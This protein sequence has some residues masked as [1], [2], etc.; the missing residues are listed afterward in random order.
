AGHGLLGAAVALAEDGLTVFTG[1]ISLSTHPWL[2]DHVVGGAVLVPGTAFVELALH[3]GDYV[4]CDHLEELTIEAPLV[5]EEEDHVSLQ[6]VVETAEAAGR[7][8]FRLSA[9][10]PSGTWIR[11]ATGTLVTGGDIGREDTVVRGNWPPPGARAVDLGDFYARVADLGTE[12]GPVFQGMT[13]L[14]QDGDDLYAEIDLP[15]GTE[16]SGYGIHPALLDAALHPLATT[17]DTATEGPMLPFV[18]TGVRLHATGADSL[19]VHWTPA[20]SAAGAF[21]CRAVDPSGA[22]VLTADSLV[23]REAPKSLASA[24]GRGPGLTRLDW[25]STTLAPGGIPAGEKWGVLAAPSL[26]ASE[27]MEGNADLTELT[28]YPDVAALAEAGVDAAVLPLLWTHDGASLPETVHTRTAGLLA[29]VQE[30]LDDPR[31][32]AA[33]LLVVTRG[34][35]LVTGDVVP[36]DLAASAAWGLLRSVQSEQPGRI[37]LV[38][39]DDDQ[40]SL[41]LLP[42]V[43]AGGEPQ[44]ALRHGRAYV[45]RLTR[46]PEHPSATAS[47][48]ADVGDGTVLVTGGTGSLGALVARHL[49]VEHGVRHLLLTSRRGV[50]A[51]GARELVAELEEAGAR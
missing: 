13:A 22:P 30:W 26:A 36:T 38:D 21:R 19:R 17:R 47:G 7:H 25:T 48:F 5:L 11:H 24:R 45:P 44:S 32:E 43:L 35:D 42:A 46:L 8:T 18:L 3:A 20:D 16:V 33:R 14:W 4:G 31:L 28:E 15:S 34:A 12:Y 50:E 27:L 49:V 41:A 2:A 51:A 23:L 10:S 40:A 39:C 1:R 29:Q 9:Q 37:V 6:L